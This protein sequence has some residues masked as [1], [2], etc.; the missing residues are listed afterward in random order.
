MGTQMPRFQSFFSLF[1]HYFLLAKLATSSIRVS[2]RTSKYQSLAVAATAEAMVVVKVKVKLNSRSY[3]LSVKQQ[4]EVYNW[5]RSVRSLSI[6][7]SCFLP[8]AVP[9][10]HKTFIRGL[11]YRVV[12]THTLIMHK[13]P[14][15]LLF[16]CQRVCIRE[17]MHFIN[18]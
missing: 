15:L 2:S 9:D 6:R 10:I 7:L 14:P 11:C 3:K 16:H 18:Q 12:T 8:E 17:C 5:S 1:L 4:C 13:H